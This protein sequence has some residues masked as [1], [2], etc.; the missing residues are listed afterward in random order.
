MPVFLKLKNWPQCTLQVSL[1]TF[2]H[3]APCGQQMRRSL[4]SF[5]LQ[6]VHASCFSRNKNG[7]CLG[8]SPGIHFLGPQT[9]IYHPP[10]LRKWGVSEQH[11]RMIQGKEG[12]NMI[13]NPM[14]GTQQTRFQISR[15]KQPWNH[16]TQVYST[17]TSR[18]SQRKLLS[19]KN[20]STFTLLTLFLQSILHSVEREE[21]IFR[22]IQT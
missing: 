4:M 14:P 17:I 9:I 15:E 12:F 13:R 21:L 2:L 10:G 3:V 7:I 16:G 1:T 6:N 8:V 18:E 5:T 22:I 11:K 19:L 20:S